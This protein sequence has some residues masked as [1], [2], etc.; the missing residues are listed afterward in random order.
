MTETV[1]LLFYTARLSALRGSSLAR[2]YRF[3]PYNTNTVRAIV[4]IID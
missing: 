1:I 2:V 4:W 3:F